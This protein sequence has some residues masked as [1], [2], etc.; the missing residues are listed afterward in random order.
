MMI[1]P[2]EVV[3]EPPHRSPNQEVIIEEEYARERL[4]PL[5][6]YAEDLRH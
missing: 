2:M 3:E 5:Q 6:V 4:N 1:H